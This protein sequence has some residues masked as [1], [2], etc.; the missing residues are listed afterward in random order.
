[1]LPYRSKPKPPADLGA[2]A[3]H[4]LSLSLSLSRFLPRERPSEKR[5]AAL[6]N[7]LLLVSSTSSQN[8]N[9]GDLRPRQ[10]DDKK[11]D[12]NQLQSTGGMSIQVGISHAWCCLFIFSDFY[13]GLF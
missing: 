7:S 2:A 6:S 9:K 11:G 12:M 5:G 10:D 3:S 1:S 13:F 4:S 8:Q